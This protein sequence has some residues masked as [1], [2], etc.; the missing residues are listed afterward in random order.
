MIHNI[1]ED[2]VKKAVRIIDIE[3]IPASRRAINWVLKYNGKK[4]P[5]KLVISKANISANGVELHYKEFRTGT[6][7]KYLTKLNLEVIRIR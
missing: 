2:D 6:A 4:Y 5:V 7:R 3:G 1:I